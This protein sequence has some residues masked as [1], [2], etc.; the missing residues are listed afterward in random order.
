MHIEESQVRILAT[1]KCPILT[2]DGANAK[3]STNWNETDYSVFF[4]HNCYCHLLDDTLF[5]SV[6]YWT[7]HFYIWKWIDNVKKYN[8]LT[9]YSFNNSSQVRLAGPKAKSNC[10]WSLSPLLILTDN[11][12]GL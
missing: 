2:H 10:D 9:D 7:V 5:I 8:F 1:I 12:Y 6:P 11:E 3:F 4:L